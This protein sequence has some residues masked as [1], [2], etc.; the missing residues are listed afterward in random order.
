M[1]FTYLAVVFFSSLS[2][3]R[4]TQASPAAHKSEVLQPKAFINQETYVYPRLEFVT[5][6]STCIPPNTDV[7]IKW[8][9]GSG[10]GVEVY[11]IPQWP[12]QLEYFPIDIA[13][14]K[15]LQYVWR[16]P[17]VEEYPEGAT[18]ILGINDVVPTIGAD[19]YD[20][21]GLLKFGCSR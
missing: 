7:R 20:L 5:R 10:Q 4:G 6:F 18:F 19:W 13:K 17:K 16:T 21:T 2:L 8:E 1:F 15:S 14:T 9:G 3:L 12:G 11:Y